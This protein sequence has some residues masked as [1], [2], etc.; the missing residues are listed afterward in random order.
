MLRR[1]CIFR[2]PAVHGVA[3]KCGVVTKVFHSGP[4]VFASLIGA[5]KPG[6]SDARADL[7]SF[8]AVAKFFDHSD[9]LMPRNYGRFA[10]RQF[11]FDNVQIGSANA[12]H[13]H[14]DENLALARLGV[15]GVGE[16]ER[17]RLD[18]RR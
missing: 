12:A 10:R 11:T 4:A 17:V 8:C 7:K 6:N 2:V 3:R 15:R 14:A 9:G 1:N 16:L 18:R 5:V 13:F